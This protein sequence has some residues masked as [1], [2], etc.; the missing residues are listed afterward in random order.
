[1]AP[2]LGE[3]SGEANADSRAERVGDFGPSSSADEEGDSP[4]W[5]V[6]SLKMSSSAATACSASISSMSCSN[7]RPDSQPP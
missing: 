2:T 1:M 4:P 5:G 6:E 3:P 7:Q